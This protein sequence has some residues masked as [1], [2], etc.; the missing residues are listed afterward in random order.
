MVGLT[1]NSIRE[2][3]LKDAQGKP[4]QDP[5]RA[6]LAIDRANT[7]FQLQRNNHLCKVSDV[8][9]KEPTC[10]DKSVVIVWKQEDRKDKDRTVTV[11]NDVAFRQSVEDMHGQ[12]VS[13]FSC[14]V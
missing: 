5:S 3:I 12:F 8:L 13:P 4:F 2:R 7:V 14:P 6:E 9:K 1:S 10:K 11:G